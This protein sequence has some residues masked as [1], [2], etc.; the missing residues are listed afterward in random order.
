MLH[1]ALAA[2]L[3]PLRDDDTLDEGVF[4]PYV[5]F[6][7]AGGLDGILALGTTGES[8]LF[9]VPER[10]RVAELFVET[11]RGKRQGAVNAG[12]ASAAG[13]VKLAAHAAE[14]GA[15]PVAVIAPPY[16]PLDDA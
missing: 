16:F 14:A 13:T 9:S 6:L 7:T 11:A 5:D 15:G 3:T 2:A 8:L 4:A 10:R 12:A 1:G